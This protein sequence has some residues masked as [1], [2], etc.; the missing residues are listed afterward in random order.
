MV[1]AGFLPVP[2]TPET[3]TGSCFSDFE[4]PKTAQVHSSEKPRKCL[5]YGPCRVKVTLGASKAPFFEKTRKHRKNEDHSEPCTGPSQNHFGYPREAVLDIQNHFAI[6][7]GFRFRFRC[8]FGAPK[9][10]KMY[11]R[12]FPNLKIDSCEDS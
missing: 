11:F 4:P 9:C 10:S 5:N 8:P 7:F 3:C 6:L 1:P 12:R 2:A